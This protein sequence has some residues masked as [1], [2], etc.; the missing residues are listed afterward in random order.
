MLNLFQ[1]FTRIYFDLLFDVSSLPEIP[2][3]SNSADVGWNLGLFGEPRQWRGI[4][5]LRGA[6]RFA[7]SPRC[8]S[9]FAMVSPWIC[10]RSLLWTMAAV[11]IPMQPSFGEN[12]SFFLI[13][14]CIFSGAYFLQ[15]MAIIAPNSNK[16][17]HGLWKQLQS[18]EKHVSMNINEHQRWLGTKIDRNHGWDCMIC[19]YRNLIPERN[20]SEHPIETEK[21]QKGSDL[22]RRKRRNDVRETMSAIACC[23]SPGLVLQVWSSDLDWSLVHLISSSLVLF[24]FSTDNQHPRFVFFSD[25]CRSKCVTFEVWQGCF[26]AAR[27]SPDRSAADQPSPCH[28]FCCGSHP[29]RTPFGSPSC[30]WGFPRFHGG[31]TGLP[32]I[33]VHQMVEKNFMEKAS[34]GILPI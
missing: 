3:V 6:Q 7:T 32:L 31:F 12:L 17:T 33:M 10:P 18:V 25:W 15:I 13:S 5:H 22:S 9:R 27:W 19:C 26:L 11:T 1:N 14:L 34:H 16:K 23:P 21:K 4:L 29:F 24:F 28:G 20:H 8:D 30:D 2:G